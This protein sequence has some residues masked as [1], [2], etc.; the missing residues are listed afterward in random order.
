MGET[1]SAIF[2]KED[3]S[4][5]VEFPDLPGCHTYGDSIEETTANAYEALSG[6]LAALSEQNADNTEADEGMTDKQ[7]TVFL[8]MILALIESS[9]SLDE[10]KEKIKALLEE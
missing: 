6:Y 8:K 4:Y 7:M 2:H 1:F 5:W 10:A 3:G 9:K